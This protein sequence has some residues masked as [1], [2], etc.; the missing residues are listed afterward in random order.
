MCL[1]HSTIIRNRLFGFPF[2]HQIT[3]IKRSLSL[4]LFI[5][6]YLCGVCSPYD[7]Q[8]WII[9]WLLMFYVSTWFNLN[10]IRFFLSS[11]DYSLS[12]GIFIPVKGHTIAR[13]TNIC[14]MH[15]NSSEVHRR[16][17]CDSLSNSRMWRSIIHSSIHSWMGI[18]RMR[19]F[20]PFWWVLPSH[21]TLGMDII[22]KLFRSFP[23]FR[24]NPFH[25]SIA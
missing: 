21:S 15:A 24:R 17:Q 9:N 22:P 11:D 10:N 8:K 5:F 1:S 16:V 3:I 12:W 23:R 6:P 19:Q 4:T 2:S 7:Y 14:N 18:I 25:R 20:S 13:V